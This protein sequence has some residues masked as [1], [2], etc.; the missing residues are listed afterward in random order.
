MQT[1]ERQ[2]LVDILPLKIVLEESEPGGK[3]VAKGEFARSDVPT[4]NRRVYPRALWERELKRLENDINE[5][6]VYG[7]LDHPGDGKTKLSRA[8]HILSEAYVDPNG[9]IIG[10]AEVMETAQGKQLKAIVEAGGVVGVSSR[11]YGSTKKTED[12]YEE[13]QD[14]Y[15]L[16][17]FDFV[18]D[19]ANG[20]SFPK[21]YQ[22]S[23][24]TKSS[25]LLEEK[26]GLK[27][28]DVLKDQ[29]LVTQLF[30]ALKPRFAEEHAEVL[31]DF[32]KRYAEQLVPMIESRVKDAKKEAFEQ[33]KSQLMSDPEVAGAKTA[34]GTL[35][36]ILRPFILSED[37]DAEISN[38]EVQIKELKAKIESRDKE[39]GE[40]K[41]KIEELGKITKELGYNLFIERN[42]LGRADRQTVIERV[43]DVGTYDST[44]VLKAKIEA[45]IKDLDAASK[46]QEQKTEA[47]NSEIEGLKKKIDDQNTL[48]NR[49]ISEAKEMG[50]RL[51]L[52]RKMKKNPKLEAA[53]PK[54][55]KM[56]EEGKIK[57]AQDMESI[58]EQFNV[59][60]RTVNEYDK[61]RERN[62][63]MR[64]VPNL[65]ESQ[66]DEARGNRNSKDDGGVLDEELGGVE[67][68]EVMALAGLATKQ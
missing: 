19:P 4:A 59:A 62:S 43:G 55:L 47:K 45:V 48:L 14:D 18:A 52:E 41:V 5:R 23:T 22:E 39:L 11:G 57:T 49:V 40:M 38:R 10:K 66:M 26:M 46:K 65:V 25:T 28:E 24:E 31:E 68:G 2:L 42:V 1:K 64:R 53:S 15:T 51:I 60:N 44:E 7:E 67:L 6:K 54:V 13:V 21:F 33:A 17:T 56:L 9:A 12:G 20:A 35:K 32:K 8:S 58:C 27:V 30:E 34:L 61:I 36:N 50:L 37:V 29:G 63:R 3:L 16:M